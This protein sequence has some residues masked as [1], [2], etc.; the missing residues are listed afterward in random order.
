V[1]CFDPVAALADDVRRRFGGTSFPSPDALLDLRDLDAVLIAAPHHEHA[2]LAMEAL[3]AGLHVIVEK[4]LA[5]DLT[6][7]IELAEAAKRSGRI[8]STCFPYR[9]EPAVTAARQLVQDG[10]LGTFTGSLLSFL[11]DK[12]PSYWLGGWTGRTSSVWRSSRSQAGGGV[13]IMNL[14]HYLDLMRHLTGEEV[15]AVAAVTGSAEARSEV[16]DTVSLTIRYENGAVGSVIGSSAAPGSN[17]ARLELWGMDG[18][19]Q[20]EPTGRTYTRRVADGLRPGRWFSLP[21]ASQVD[22]RVVY[23]SRLATAIH[24]GLEPDVTLADGLAVQAIME[25][26]YRSSE[27]REFIRPADL[28]GERVDAS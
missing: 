7:A 4:P 19:V 22:T 17:E 12:P 20:V 28:L 3:Q 1:G 8:V 15:E 14:C 13:L 24:Q 2:P 10:A 11:I 18:R 23:F 16:E 6:A 21:A 25:A 5:N 26:A 27:T 9:Y